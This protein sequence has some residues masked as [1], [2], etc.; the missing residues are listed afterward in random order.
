MGLLHG[1]TDCLPKY[2]YD[3]CL[4]GRTEYMAKMDR[5]E[6]LSYLYIFFLFH[7]VSQLASKYTADVEIPTCPFQSQ[8]L[9][10]ELSGVGSLASL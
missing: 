4:S 10:S 6:S 7:V 5:L 3:G 8:N 2:D 1:E 9:S